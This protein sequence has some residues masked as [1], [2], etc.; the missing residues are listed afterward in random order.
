M[1]KS[2][3]CDARCHNATGEICACWCGGAF[4]GKGGQKNRE[5][6]LDNPE[7]LKE[8]FSTAPRGSKFEPDLFFGQ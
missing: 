8:M 7:Y 3:S 1:S 4:H 6:V 2:K 5:R